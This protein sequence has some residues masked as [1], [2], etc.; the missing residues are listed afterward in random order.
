M[1]N[2]LA[3]LPTSA[4]PEQQAY[5]VGQNGNVYATGANGVQN[6]GAPTSAPTA[7]GVETQTA[8]LQAQQIADPNAPA[9]TGGSTTGGSTGLAGTTLN[10][11]G[12]IAGIQQEYGGQIA[13]A[14]TTQ[15]L[16]TQGLGIDI[17]TPQNGLGVTGAA[18][19]QIGQQQAQANSQLGTLGTE[20]NTT[21]AQQNLSLSELAA[22]IRAQNQGLGAQLGAVGAGSSSAVGQGQQGLAQEQNTDRANIQQ[23]TAGNIANINSQEQ[24]V[25]SVLGANIAAI[26]QW[27]NTQ[28]ATIQNNYAQM[29]NNINTAVSTASGEEQARLAEF[30]QATTDSALQA[31]TNINNT[32]QQA[33]NSALQSG[34][35]ALGAQQPVP[36]AQAVNPIAVNTVSPFSVT[37]QSGAA[38]NAGAAPTGGGLDALLQQQQN[39]QQA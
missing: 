18:A 34:T 2:S 39:Q 26:N 12:Y 28:A 19:A 8:S 29:M 17:G 36:Q 6:F 14:P 15:N 30:G 1:Q 9:S 32:S 16:Y 24:G 35:S 21:Q 38:A 13:A 20:A 5:W 27:K 7:N 3:A 23:Q 25:N 37:P 22:Q 11:P 33:V 10:A 31:L 4:T